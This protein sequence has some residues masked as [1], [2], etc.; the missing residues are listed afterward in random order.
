MLV[1]CLEYYETEISKNVKNKKKL[2]DFEINKMQYVE[3]IINMLNNGVVGHKHYN[4][5]LIF[6]NGLS[7]IVNDNLPFSI[8][9]LIYLFLKFVLRLNS[10]FSII[11]LNDFGVLQ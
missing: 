4:I 6:E 8:N 9:G 7:G 10:D 3:D 1:I 5:F 11:Y 2:Y